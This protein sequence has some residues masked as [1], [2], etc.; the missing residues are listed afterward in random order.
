MGFKDENNKIVGF[1][2]DVAQEVCNRLGIKLKTQPI[3]WDF[4]EDELVAGNIDCIWNGMSYSDERAE[5]MTLS[6][7]YMNNS[8]VLVVLKGSGYKTQ[9]DLKNKKV[10]VQNASTAQDILNNSDFKKTLKEVISLKDNTSAFVELEMK[11]VDAVL[12]ML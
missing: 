3:D 9:A 6:K 11:T 1:D 2:I 10:A 8:M 12:L 4:K 7:P 5:K